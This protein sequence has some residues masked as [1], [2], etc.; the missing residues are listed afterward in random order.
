MIILSTGRISGAHLNP[1]LMI[2][3]VALHH[4]S[5]AQVPAYILAQ[6]SASIGASFAFK[7]VFHPFMSSGVTV[8]SVST[9]QAFALEFLITFS[10]LFVVT[11]VATDTRGRIGMYCS[12][13]Y[14]YIP[15]VN[16]LGQFRE[17]IWVSLPALIYINA[18]GRGLCFCINQL[19]Q[20]REAIQVAAD[21]TTNGGIPA[22]GVSCQR[23]RGCLATS[24]PLIDEVNS[25]L[26]QLRTADHE[27]LT[28]MKTEFM[29]LWDGFTVD[30][31][32]VSLFKNSS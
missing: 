14:C 27:A 11:A 4:F 6:V 32:S 1:S 8:P 12:W 20:F 9:G 29:A 16:P 30:R 23:L 19:R 28:N 2:A 26:S 18:I 10:L 3:F 13:S 17:A 15:Q 7:G 24:E 21:A 22:V 25:F 31:K 5:W